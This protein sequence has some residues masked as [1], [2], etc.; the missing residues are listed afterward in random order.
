[1]LVTG[2][3]GFIGRYVAQK[4][5]KNGYYVIGMGHGSLSPEEKKEY[6]I[7]LYCSCDVTFYNLKNIVHDVD[8]VVHCAGSGSVGFSFEHPAK[9]FSRTVETT[10]DVLEFVRTC[11]PNARVVYPSSAA[12]YGNNNKLPLCENDECN[13]ISPYGYHKKMAE[14]LCEMYAKTYNISVII[15]RLFSVYGIGLKKQL[16]WDACNKV[17]EEKYE[18]WGTGNEHR[19]WIHVKDVAAYLYEAA[20]YA[21]NKCDKF[22]LACGEM[23]SISDVLSELFNAYG[24]NQLPQFGGQENLG[25]PK[26]YLADVHKIKMWNTKIKYDLKDGIKAYVDWYKSQG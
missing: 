4:F 5:H 7:D 25:N 3:M 11:C 9:D 26:D 22:N 21:S 19:D 18:F 24:V 20:E 17:K 13:P 6:G 23:T 1:M 15:M 10:K 16:L 2:A 14:E 8:I 12:V